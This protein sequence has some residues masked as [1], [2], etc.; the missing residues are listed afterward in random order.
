MFFS[1]F[2]CFCYTINVLQ[3]YEIPGVTTCMAYAGTEYTYAPKHIEDLS[4]GSVNVVFP[5][6]A[7]K[8][9]LLLVLQCNETYDFLA[10]AWIRSAILWCC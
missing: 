5:D 10:M 4:L 2:Y 1:L 6:S 9:S 3:G 7:P 8:V